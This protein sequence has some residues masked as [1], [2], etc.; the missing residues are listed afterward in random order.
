MI[1]LHC[2]LLP[3]I[4]D[5][6]RDLEQALCLARMS[7]ADGITHCVVTP[8]IHPGRYTNTLGSITEVFTAFKAVLVKE[9]I[10][11]QLGI[12][13]EI[14]LSEEILDMVA[15]RQVPFLGNWEGGKVLLL[16]L[17]HSHIPPGV[18]QL[19]HWLRKQK[20]RPMIAHPERNKDVLRDFRKVLPL[21]RLGCLFQVT[22]GAVAGDFGE[23]PKQ[24]ARE[25]LERDLVTAL[26]TDA[27]HEV[28]RPPVLEKGRRAAEAIVGES[29]SW[30]LVRLNPARIAAS[31]FVI[32]NHVRRNSA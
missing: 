14:R 16:E 7:V 4:D 23:G 11:L 1:D 8:H 28:R 2:H 20:I 9:G 12:A 26:A 29:K 31:H 32:A 17:P 22:A 13:A 21:A 6:A 15:T 5:G 30:E 3:G 25:L 27:H 10:P 18:E 24:R 19:I